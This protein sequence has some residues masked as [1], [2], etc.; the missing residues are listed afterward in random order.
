VDAERLD[1]ERV[2]RFSSGTRI[3]HWTIAA[4]FVL[5]LLSGLALFEPAFY[6]LSALF[7]GGP[8]MRILHPYIGAALGILFF[9]YAGGIWREN[10][11]LAS[12]YE[13]LRQSRAILF[14]KVELPVEG[15][16]NAGQK[17]LFWILGAL[18]LGLLA[19]GVLIWRPWFAHAFSGET[20][21]IAVIVH[22]LCGFAMF[23]AIGIHV[24]AAYWTRGSIFGMV[25]GWVP[26]RWAR[27]HHPEWYR[28]V[29]AEGAPGGKSSR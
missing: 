21:R 27:F 17:V 5:A 9:A 4:A 11:L 25:R 7:G 3:V 10:L 15:K 13:W 6:W 12:D 26:A 28:R 8:F 16:Y 18:I 14:K 24:Y 20:R 1:E 2:P 19:T 23:V 29:R 22:A